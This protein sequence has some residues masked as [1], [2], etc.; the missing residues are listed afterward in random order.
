MLLLLLSRF[1]CVWLFAIPWTE[2]AR[3]LCPSPSPKVCPSLCP[4]HW[5]CHPAISSS[6]AL[7][8]FCPQSFPASGTFPMS[9]LLAPDDQNTRVSASA[10]APP[11]SI[12]GLLPK[13]WLIWSPCCPRDSRE[14]SPAPQFKGIDSSALCFLYGP[15]L[16]TVCDRWEDHSLDC[17]DL[18]WHH[19]FCF[20]WLDKPIPVDHN[21]PCPSD[22]EAVSLLFTRFALPLFC[23]L[24]EP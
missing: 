7:F 6:D 12:Q 10:S 13:D 3:L 2:H 9:W 4:L 14:S 22:T 17:T 8:S 1:S 5:W 21:I 15:A 24:F 18:C 23:H 11:M 19:S 20:S 16:T